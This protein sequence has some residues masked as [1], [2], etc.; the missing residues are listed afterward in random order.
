MICS[1]CQVALVEDLPSQT[2]ANTASDLANQPFVLAWSGGDA[3]RNA[4]VV[5][6]L[7]R[8]NIPAKT[9]R[10]QDF[11]VLPTT[12]SPFEVYVPASFAKQAKE[13]LQ[14]E[15]PSEQDSEEAADS[16][17]FEIPA[18]DDFQ[19]DANQGQRRRDWHPDDATAEIWS[20]EDF[21]LADMIAM[22]LRENQIYSRFDSDSA[23]PEGAPPASEK[24]YVLPED[25]ARAIKIVREIVDAAPP[26]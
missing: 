10:E 11:F 12:R 9:L 21:H 6:M 22:S 26:Q 13:V 19:D 20:G 2:S 4:E 23:D 8:E 3:R 14:E 18:E 25:E 16:G 24:L 15:D 5:A 17:A 1:D 7:G